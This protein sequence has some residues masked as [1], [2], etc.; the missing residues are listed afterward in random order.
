M[1][2]RKPSHIEALKAVARALDDLADA[3]YA[4]AES[5]S[6]D[7]MGSEDYDARKHRTA[8]DEHTGVCQSALLVYTM[9]DEARRS[10]A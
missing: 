6:L 10:A 7:R 9:I 2:N 4:V 5:F 1:S 8:V 3:K